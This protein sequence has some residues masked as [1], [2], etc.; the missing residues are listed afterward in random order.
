MKRITYKPP[1]QQERIR[2][3]GYS[4]LEQTPTE[5]QPYTDCFVSLPTPTKDDDWL[6]EHKE[7][8]Q[9]YAMWQRDWREICSV[10][11]MNKLTNNRRDSIK[12]Y[13]QPI[14]VISSDFV[15]GL[16]EFVSVYYPGV[17]VV[18][19]TPLII[20]GDTI[21]SNTISSIQLVTRK[22]PHKQYKI[23]S[24][25]SVLSSMKQ[26]DAFCLVGITMEDL[27]IDNTTEYTVGLAD[28]ATNTA[29]FSFMRYLSDINKNKKTITSIE[30]SKERL[31]LRRCC[32]VIIHEIAHLFGI[33]HCVWYSCCMNGSGH[34][35]EDYNRPLHMC[36]VCLRKV[37]VVIACGVL[38]R[39]K[40]LLV[41]YKKNGFVEE[42]RWCNRIIE[43][44][45]DV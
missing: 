23:E 32:K 9:S 31:L 40:G 19:N 37:V 3:C 29:V 33:S 16:R 7:K 35:E 21:S 27:Y 26:K 20:D 5:Y 44:I 43:H 39:Y 2:G 12:I 25:L 36:V 28:H 6:V 1:T 38:E 14:G 11:G 8:R 45:Q 30:S 34:L 13:L 42:E 18:V 10:I 41:Y 22:R 24:L 15:T 4:T 17:V